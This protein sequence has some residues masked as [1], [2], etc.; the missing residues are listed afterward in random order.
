MAFPEF[1]KGAAIG[2]GA[3]IFF[4]LLRRRA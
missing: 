4:F 3:L 2:A 1:A